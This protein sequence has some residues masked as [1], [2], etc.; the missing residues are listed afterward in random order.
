MRGW[1]LLALS[2][3]LALGTAFAAA[4]EGQA[5]NNAGALPGAKEWQ[6]PVARVPMLV[7][8]QVVEVNLKENIFTVATKPK[9]RQ[10]AG[11]VVVAVNRDTE[12][13]KTELCLPRHLRLGDTV[14]VQGLRPEPL[15]VPLFAKGEVTALDPLTVAPAREVAVVIRPGAEVSFLRLGELSLTE[16]A[17]GVEVKAIAWRGEEPLVAKEVRALFVLPGA[18]KPAPEEGSAG[19]AQG[20]QAPR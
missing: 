18:S 9:R 8:G 13:V 14:V 19:A 16:L 4:G 17:P 20:E 1:R 7:D 11:R 10:P 15:G 5:E 3:C 6:A 12:L 2:A